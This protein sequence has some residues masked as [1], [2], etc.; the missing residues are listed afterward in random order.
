M[1]VRFPYVTGKDYI[2]SVD[3]FFRN[4][5]LQYI[6]KR[7]ELREAEQQLQEQRNF[8][9]TFMAGLRVKRAKLA[10]NRLHLRDSIE[11][12][13]GQIIRNISTMEAALK[14]PA[15][16]REMTNKL[17]SKIKELRWKWLQLRF[18]KDITRSMVR[19]TEALVSNFKGKPRLREFFERYQSLFGTMAQLNLKQESLD[20]KFW[21]TKQAAMA[22]LHVLEA[23]FASVNR[24][25]RLKAIEFDRATHAFDELSL[26]L[27]DI[28]D[29]ASRYSLTM[30]H[31]K[32]VVRDLY[33]KCPSFS[34]RREETEDFDEQLAC[35]RN[36]VTTFSNIDHLH[37]FDDER[38]ERRHS[39]ASE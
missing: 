11:S 10:Q 32:F 34:K 4:Y 15:S 24:Q 23:K 21:E 27:T 14:K 35:I 8:H 20:K 36:F 29:C 5:K 2:H 13:S 1:F 18:K 22:N 30:G 38:R 17:I 25:M 37:A 28:M 6:D 12:M 7:L 33:I 31:I 26:V 9:E 19:K 3:P 16:E 39:S